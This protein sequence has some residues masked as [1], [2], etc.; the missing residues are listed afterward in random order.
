VPITSVR[1]RCV[2]QSLSTEFGDGYLVLAA[3]T[4]FFADWA[5]LVLCDL[6]VNTLRMA[7]L[8]VSGSECVLYLTVAQQVAT[9]GSQCTVYPICDR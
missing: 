2:T 5:E 4:W 8:L 7:D 9:T 1:L 6:A 3:N